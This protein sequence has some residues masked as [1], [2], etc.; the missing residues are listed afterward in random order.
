MSAELLGVS[1]EPVARQQRFRIPLCREPPQDILEPLQGV[2]AGGLAGSEEGVDDGRADGG[3]VVAAE[4]IVL[5]AEGQRADS[6][7]HA[8]VVDVV[9][10]VEPS[11][12][13]ICRN[14]QSKN[15]GPFREFNYL[16]NIS[17][18]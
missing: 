14:I 16:W 6:V 7:L 1:G 2:N 4:E 12:W 9:P 13:N 17:E 15:V 3:V 8:V 5:A 18:S 11:A 10:A